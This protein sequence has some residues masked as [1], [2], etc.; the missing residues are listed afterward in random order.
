[1]SNIS[2]NINDTT[3]T[4]TTITATNSSSSN[5]EV[6]SVESTSNSAEKKT[7]I[8]PPSATTTTSTSTGKKKTK[9]KIGVP[10]TVLTGF[11]GSGKTTLL[12]HILDNK[13]GLKVA[14]IENEFGAVG[15]D[16]TLINKRNKVSTEDEIVEMMNG[17]ICCTVRKDLQEVI[18]KLLITEKRNLDAIIIETTGLADPAPVAQTFF[19]DETIRKACYLDAIITVVDAKHILGQLSRERPEGVE[20]EA[21]EQLCFADKIILNKIDLLMDDPKDSTGTTNENTSSVEKENEKEEKI[22]TI[23]GK[24]RKYNPT[25][26]ILQTTFS[27]IDPERIMGLDAFS[28]EKVLEVEPDFLNEDSQDHQH[29]TTVTSFCVASDK[30]MSTALL[31]A[32]IENLLEKHGNNLFRYKGIIY[33]KGMEKRFVFQGIHMLFSGSFT[34]PWG[35]GEKR[36]SKLVFIGRNLPTQ[37]IQDEFESCEAKTLRFPVGTRVKAKVLLG[38]K[39]AV[40]LNQW[41]EGNAYRIRLDNGTEVWAPI[42]SDEYVKKA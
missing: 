16:D 28:L 15:I 2:S 1:M 11:L 37:R 12:N 19:V 22:N 18:R 7:S 9:Q 3:T 38:F 40:I 31:Q 27:T 42:D 21:E 26:E 24:I 34:T 33:V 10:V 20:N 25:A 32:W 6:V 8:P 14:V 13:Q 5:N 35:N 39:N 29:D 41:D 23:I 30:E 36:E 4:G 17:C